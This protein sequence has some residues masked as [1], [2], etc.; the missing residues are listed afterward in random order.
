LSEQTPYTGLDR[1]A[2]AIGTAGGAGLL[3][4]APGTWGSA[5]VTV[6]LYAL[7][8]TGLSTFHGPVACACLVGLSIA[9]GWA[10]IW[11]GERMARVLKDDDPSPVVID[12]VVGQ[13]LTYSLLPVAGRAW[14]G[15][16]FEVALVVGFFLFRGLD[17]VKPGPVDDL[18]RFHGGIGI[19][20]DDFLAGI[21]GGWAMLVGAMIL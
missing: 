7:Y 12:E 11:A 14:T 16:S 8:A 18:Q 6:A 10:G 4:V 3:P 19:M 1:L 9:L 5:V 21:V 2:F 15:V 20:A 13:L 17:I